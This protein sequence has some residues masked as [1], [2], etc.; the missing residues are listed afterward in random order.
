VKAPR[1]AGKETDMTRVS[2]EKKPG[3]P[4]LGGWRDLMEDL[5]RLQRRVA[6]ADGHCQCGHPAGIDAVCPCCD[7]TAR[8]LASVCQVCSLEIEAVAERVERIE[9]DT[10]RFLPTV[11]ALFDRTP[12][13]HEEAIAVQDSVAQLLRMFRQL[14][15]ATDEWAQGC[16]TTH[17]PAVKA[18]AEDLAIACRQFDDVLRRLR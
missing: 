1:S 16:Q 14:R 3:H 11:F 10:L 12:E 8:E 17:L 9:E 13:R 6:T 2:L 15:S 18:R 7:R 4:L 5:L